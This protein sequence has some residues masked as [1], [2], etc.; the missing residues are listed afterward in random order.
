MIYIFLSNNPS[1]RDINSSNLSCFKI[2]TCWP[3]GNFLYEVG[4]ELFAW[5][6]IFAFC[7]LSCVLNFMGTLQFFKSG[8]FVF[9]GRFSNNLAGLTFVVV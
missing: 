2:R 5:N 9:I 3:T 4:F 1:S 7:F 6:L 8:S